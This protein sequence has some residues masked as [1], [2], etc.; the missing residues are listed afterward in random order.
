MF[1]FQLGTIDVR[2]SITNKSHMASYNP[3]N[4]QKPVDDDDDPVEK[5]L[6]KT[7]CLELHYA[8]Q[9]CVAD[10]KDWRKCQSQVQEFR[11]CVEANKEKAK[12]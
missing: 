10:T 12:K 3:H 4:R 11:K 1:F 8:V 6:K 7:G 2:I 9:E 5:M